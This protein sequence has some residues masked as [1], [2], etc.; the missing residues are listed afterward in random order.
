MYLIRTF[1][2]DKHNYLLPT[3][4]HFKVDPDKTLLG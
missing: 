3:T 2:A 1:V 4:E